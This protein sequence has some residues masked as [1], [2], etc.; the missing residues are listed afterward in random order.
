MNER[1]VTPRQPII[2]GRA[3]YQNFRQFSVTVDHVIK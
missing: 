2:T 3:S 1:Y